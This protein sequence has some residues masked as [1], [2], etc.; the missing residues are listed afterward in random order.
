MPCYRT[1]SYERLLYDFHRQHCIPRAHED[2]VAQAI[3]TFTHCHNYV[4][5]ILTYT[6]LF[7]VIFKLIN[8]NNYSIYFHCFTFNTSNL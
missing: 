1:I 3:F 5:H 8:W 4:A 7:S 2:N 6:N